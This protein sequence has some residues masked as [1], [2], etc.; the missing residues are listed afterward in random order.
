MGYI[1]LLSID[2][3]YLATNGSS[4][5]GISKKL[6]LSLSELLLTSD[7]LRL[8]QVLE[9][10]SVPS[11]YH[12]PISSVFYIDR[13]KC[14][15]FSKINMNE[16]DPFEI[17][18]I[19]SVFDGMT[20]TKAH[21]IE[22]KLQKKQSLAD[23]E[24]LW[25]ELLES[26]LTLDNLQILRP[27]ITCRNT[28][29]NSFRL[30]EYDNFDSEEIMITN[31]HPNIL[32]VGDQ[33]TITGNSFGPYKEWVNVAISGY[34]AEII[35]YNEQKGEI[36]VVVPKEAKDE[37]FIE[38]DVNGV[39][40][41]LPFYI[42]I[43]PS[44][45]TT[46]CE[47]DAQLKIEVHGTAHPCLIDVHRKSEIIPSETIILQTNYYCGVNSCLLPL[48]GTAGKFF[49]DTIS[50]NSVIDP[51][52]YGLPE[53]SLTLPFYAVTYIQ[54]VRRKEK[55]KITKK[56]I[57][58]Y[59]FYRNGK[60]W[61]I[62]DKK[63]KHPKDDKGIDLREGANPNYKEAD[64]KV[65]KELNKKFF[66]T[67]WEKAWEGFDKEAAFQLQMMAGMLLAMQG[68]SEE[69]AKLIMQIKKMRID[70][71]DWDAILDKKWWAI[72]K[73]LLFAGA[74]A[75]TG[76][77]LSRFLGKLF[78]LRFLKKLTKVDELE[79]QITITVKKKFRSGPNVKKGITGE[80]KGRVDKGKGILDCDPVAVDWVNK[81][82][83]RG[84]A[85]DLFRTWIEKLLEFAKK[86]GLKKVRIRR[87]ARSKSGEKMME[88]L[89]FKKIFNGK[90]G[91]VWE[92]VI[93]VK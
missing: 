16:I 74:T 73:I 18:E 83:K 48:G 85:T 19:L 88:R 49:V 3:E 47:D 39:S 87:A 24:A 29:K 34:P 70:G 93:D 90:S 61:Q 80:I 31:V 36:K 15:C 7:E 52:I 53:F 2:P 5:K 71:K 30:N 89:G 43:E 67:G 40:N 86:K 91:S 35:S 75:G 10:L 81:T 9:E 26:N 4:I 14:R 37:A 42:Q 13:D 65:A 21:R 72:L 45:T 57:V 82:G 25:K 78:K 92:K 68:I 12:K 33:L 60:W 69:D 66:P 20:K 44:F 84:L 59:Y 27:W 76:A 62:I 17:A 11:N 51:A 55:D 23:E 32:K 50:F 6:A 38:L 46:S 64:A 54:L 77:L 8:E 41:I 58:V 79:D 22:I 56:D 1:N 63:K 28:S